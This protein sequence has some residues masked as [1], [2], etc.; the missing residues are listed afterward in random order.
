MLL[1]LVKPKLIPVALV[2]TA[3]IS[4]AAQTV[5]QTADSLLTEAEELFQKNTPEAREA[6]FPKF[7][8][9]L[10][11]AEQQSDLGLQ[12]KALERL[13]DISFYRNDYRA[14][15]LFAERRLAIVRKSGDRASEGQTI[16]NIGFYKHLLG[17]SREGLELLEQAAKILAE[18]GDKKSQSTVYSNLGLIHYEFGRVRM[19]LDFFERSMVLKREIGDRKGESIL[20]TNLGYISN[21]AGK[22][23]EALKYYFKALELAR[24][25]KDQ[26]TEGTLLSNIG[27]VYQDLA[28]YE[29][30][31]ENYQLSLSIRRKIGERYGEA[32]VI[33]N[34][35]TLYRAVGDNQSAM[36]LLDFAR[37]IYKDGG[38]NR[39]LAGILSS[40]GALHKSDKRYDLATKSLNEALE[41][42]KRLDNKSGFSLIHGNIG[43]LDLELGNFARARLSFEESLRAAIESGDVSSIAYARMMLG[44]SLAKIGLN[45]GAEEHFNAAI[46]DSKK[47]GT[48]ELIAEALY[49]SAIFENDRGN[50]N[51]AIKRVGEAVEIVETVR[52]AIVSRDFQ[53]RFFGEQQRYYEFLIKLLVGRHRQ[54]PDGGFGAR[55]LLASEQARARS[56]LDSLGEN[57][58]ALNSSIPPELSEQDDIVKRNIRDAESRRIDALGKRD[59]KL[60]SEIEIEIT[61][62]LREFDSLQT[63]IRLAN[64]QAAS[65]TNPNPLGI[66]E[67]RKSVIDDDSVLLEYF[68]GESA[69]FLFMVDHEELTIAELPGR[70]TIDGLVRDTMNSITA[71]AV[72]K[73]GESPRAR[74]KRVGE[75]DLLLNKTLSEAGR[76]LLSPV[77]ARFADKRLL[78]VPSGSLQYLPFAAVLLISRQDSTGKTRA[79]NAARQNHLIETNEVVVLPSASVVPLLRSQKQ[80]SSPRKGAISVIADPVFSRDD[81]RLGALKPNAAPSPEIDAGPLRKPSLRADFARLRFSRV[82]AENILTFAGE[83]Q[84]RIALDFDANID[85]ARA[86]TTR[87]SSILHFATHGR[88]DGRFPELS[89]IVLSLVDSEGRSRDGFLRLSEIYGFRLETDLVV[90]SACETALGPDIRGEGLIGLTR[91][92]MFA[93]SPRVVASLWRIDDRATADL[94]KRFYQRMFRENLS[95]SASLR[96]AQL[97]MLREK[98]SS[99]P[100]F[101]SAFTLQGE[102]K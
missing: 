37:D 68:I 90:L 55:A 25:S 39:E 49:H 53:A 8:S 56:L 2:I 78:I 92:F 47:S 31:F 21:E 102:W 80:I 15:I 42:Q 76:L 24:E 11:I 94:M 26:L 72:L 19:S 95:V 58:R 17:N 97:S 38:F 88:I 79:A 87:K 54:N 61:R 71:R 44:R 12:A 74:T 41:L 18:F 60:A 83:G 27:S 14:T 51:L 59:A 9:A 85:F 96:Q 35:A 99:H 81:S 70:A 32:V 52:S 30:A 64:P 3:A 13:K 36:W 7:E 57:R 65:I 62:L 63:K 28:D 100:F 29:K 40:I 46:E 20:L 84:S 22:R 4:L 23:D 89:S 5:A 77:R 34:L 67:I 66:D 45:D 73:S 6:A 50:P 91:G 10:R 86:E 75:A 16:G 69:S 93:G 82:E 33:Q 98:A 48:P 43:A 101:W 1:H